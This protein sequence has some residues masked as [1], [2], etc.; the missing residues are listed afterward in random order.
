MTVLFKVSP[1]G[2][3][4]GDFLRLSA[5]PY[6]P[7]RLAA[8]DRVFFWWSETQ[9]GVGLA[10]HGLCVRV[11]G[12]SGDMTVEVE[13]IQFA[14]TGFGKQDLA[15]HRSAGPGTPLGRLA[16]KLYKNSLNKVVMVDRGEEEFL[17]AQFAAI[18]R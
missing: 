14:N 4:D 2:P 17:D 11:L 16:A 8:G 10:G 15:P 7:V 18:A 12:A 6:G 3:F 1:P 13:P 9:K 5:R